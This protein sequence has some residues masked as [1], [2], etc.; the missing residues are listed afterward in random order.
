M[1]A[2]AKG[3]LLLVQQLSAALGQHTHPSQVE[4]TAHAWLLIAQANS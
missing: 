4:T 2:T 3:Q 1:S